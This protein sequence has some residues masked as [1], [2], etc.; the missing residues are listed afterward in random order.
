MRE[1]AFKYTTLLQFSRDITGHCYT[2]RCL[3]LSD[4]RQTVR[5]PVCH[6]LP[7]G[8]EH[9]QSRDS[10]GNLLLCGRYDDPHSS[11]SFTVT[12]KAFLQNSYTTSGCASALYGY[13]SPLTAPGEGILQFYRENKPLGGTVLNRALK[14]SD[15]L[16]RHMAYQKGVT[17]VNTTGEEAF[18]L[19]SGVCQDYAHIFLSLCR[20]DGIRCRYVSGLAYEEGETHAWAEV[21]DGAAWYGIDP[22]S[23]RLIDAHYLK[24]CHGR[25]YGDCPIERGI[26]LGY[27]ESTQTV[28]SHMEA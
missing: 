2:L 5:E 26:Y 3:P 10:F 28:T 12:G 7:E 19:G 6:I 15:S 8:G 21:N 25:D 14:L 17:G 13:P 20:L 9:W 16:Y 1:L 22:T 23:N 27:A 11:F 4:D 18:L 24:L